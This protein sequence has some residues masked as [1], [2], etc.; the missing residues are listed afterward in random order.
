MRPI[1]S[2]ARARVFNIPDMSG[3]AIGDLERAELEAMFRAL[4][5]AVS[6]ANDE[7]LVEAN[8]RRRRLRPETVTRILAGLKSIDGGD[9][10]SAVLKY[11]TVAAVNYDARALAFARFNYAN[12]PKAAR[13]RVFEAWELLFAEDGPAS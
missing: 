2:T 7:A 5:R 10:R 6:S 9:P 4:E 13:E 12:L 1:G 8:R 11:A 3:G